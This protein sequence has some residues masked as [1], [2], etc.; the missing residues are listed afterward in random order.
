MTRR[1]RSKS[2]EQ[3]CWRKSDLDLLGALDVLRDGQLTRAG[4][5]IAGQT[6]AIGRHLPNLRSTLRTDEERHRL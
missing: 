1:D 6:E 3:T 2:A 5:M 4:L